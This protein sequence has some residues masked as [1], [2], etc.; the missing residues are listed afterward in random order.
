MMFRRTATT[1]LLALAVSAAALGAQGGEETFAATAALK[2]ASGAAATAPVTIVVSRKMAQDEIDKYTAAFKTGG[3]AA[4]RKALT[5]V[6]PTGS[7]RFGD[8]AP[9][10]SRMTLERTTDKGRLLTIITDQP[11]LF[12]G[13]GLPG[14][15]PKA[16]YD[17]A[18]VDIEVDAAGS[19]TG[20]LLPAARVRV[21]KGAF[22]VDDYGAER[23]QLTGV[24]LRK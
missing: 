10:P 21:D 14:A 12:L 1:G 19:G 15:K 18:I 5:G 4:L 24:K 7:V 11:I 20:T 22:V 9:I 3:P 13:A 23:I 8:Q 17:F 16:G 6:A 2:T